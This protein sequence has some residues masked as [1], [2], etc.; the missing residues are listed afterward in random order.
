MNKVYKFFLK[1]SMCHNLRTMLQVKL[2]CSSSSYTDNYLETKA[3]MTHIMNMHNRN[4]C[5]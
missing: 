4:K 5:I 1:K 3:K 2:I